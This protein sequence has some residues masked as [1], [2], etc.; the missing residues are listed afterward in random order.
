M[1]TTVASADIG[2]MSFS[3]FS[4]ELAFSRASLGMP[5]GDLLLELADLVGRLVHLAEFLLNGLHLLIQVVLAL[6]LL[7]LR[8]DAAADA[9]LDLQHVH[10]AFDRGEDVLQAL[11]HVQDLQN[12]LLLGELQRHVRGDGVG[13]P[14]GVLDAGQGGQDLRRHLLVEFDVLLELRDHGR[15]STSI[16]R[17][18]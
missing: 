8:L 10:L 4:S 17:S 14:A 18:S 3:L 11:A 2:D 15:V 7:H 13:Q 5:A 9:L 6:A 16:S 1:R 12:L